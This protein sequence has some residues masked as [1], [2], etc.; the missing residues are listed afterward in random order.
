MDNAQAIGLLVFALLFRLFLKPFLR[1]FAAR[2]KTDLDDKILDAI[3]NPL[4]IAVLLLVT[5]FFIREYVHDVWVGAIHKILY[6]LIAVF[7]GVIV[8]RLARI[9]I[10]DVFGRSRAKFIDEKTKR[11]ALIVIY[12]LTLAAVAVIAVAYILTVWG[13]DVTPILAS[14]GIAGLAI[15]LALKDPLENLFYG[16]VLAMDP[17]F[18]VGDIVE[19]DGTL[20]EVREIGLRNTELVTFSGDLVILP[21]S[22]IATSK[23]VNFHLPYEK[24]RLSIRVGAS[25][26]ND[27]EEVKNTLVEVAKDYPY[28]LD[29][30]APQAI[31]VEFGDSAIIYELR[32]WV[33]LQRKIEAL[34]WIQ[35]RIWKV[36]RDRGIE[37]P[38]PITTVYLKNAGS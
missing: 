3:T 29:D 13:V 19:V 6:S 26:D 27:P 20:G 32:V 25:Y 23:I 24:V 17:S 31:L 15:G 37:I 38:Y 8:V 5:D 35:T 12:N 34:D 28:T 9:F 2:T 1:V 30:P 11:T 10:F 7:A 21:N 14:A 4:W 33:P 18:R 36:F 22:K 16:I